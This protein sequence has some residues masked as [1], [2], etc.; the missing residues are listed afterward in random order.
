M[1]VLYTEMLI[2]SMLKQVVSV[3]QLLCAAERNKGIRYDVLP[4]R[5]DPRG[6]PSRTLTV[7]FGVRD[8]L[9]MDGWNSCGHLD[10]RCAVFHSQT[11]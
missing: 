2:I 1:L 6:G 4:L 11:T 5:I 3:S 10:R 9:D 8:S 7:G